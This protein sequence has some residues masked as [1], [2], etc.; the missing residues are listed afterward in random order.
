VARFQ[1]EPS[2]SSLVFTE[3]PWTLPT[4]C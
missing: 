3:S 1:V 2:N 4:P